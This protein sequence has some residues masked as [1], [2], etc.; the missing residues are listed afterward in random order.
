[1]NSRRWCPPCPFAGR[2]HPAATRAAWGEGRGGGIPLPLR[3]RHVKNQR[4]SSPAGMAFCSSSA[5]DHAGPGMERHSSATRPRSFRT[6]GVYITVVC[7]VGSGEPRLHA[8]D[9]GLGADRPHEG[10]CVYYG[11]EYSW[12]RRAPAA[13]SGQHGCS[14]PREGLFR[15][16]R[17]AVIGCAPLAAA[18]SGAGQPSRRDGQGPA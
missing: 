9:D 3:R 5:A 13:H 1:M 18:P 17:T 11:G 10:L 14:R 16:G 6:L 4:S 2:R 15:T 7:I 8:V 12:L